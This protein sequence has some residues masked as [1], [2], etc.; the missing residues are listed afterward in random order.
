M[1]ILWARVLV[2]FWFLPCQ[3]PLLLPWHLNSVP[4][5]AF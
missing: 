4:K 3:L 2:S 1:L 5:A